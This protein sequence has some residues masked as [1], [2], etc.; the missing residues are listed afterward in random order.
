AT[1]NVGSVFGTNKAMDALVGTA[2]QSKFDKIY[3]EAKTSLDPA[4]QERDLDQMIE[5]A[6]ASWIEIPICYV[7]ILQAFSPRVDPV[8][9]TPTLNISDRLAYWKYTGK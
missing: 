8:I 4:T 6:T 2:D 5:I 7:S 3:A 1:E 9:T